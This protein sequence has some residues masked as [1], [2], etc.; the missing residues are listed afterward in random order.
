MTQLTTTRTAG[1]RMP[2]TGGGATDSISAEVAGRRIMGPIPPDPD[3]PARKQMFALM[4]SLD[5]DLVMSDAEGLLA[6]AG[7]DPA[8]DTSRVGAVGYCMSGRYAISLAVRHP[9]RVFAAASVYGTQLVTEAEDSPHRTSRLA[10]AELYYA[11]AEEDVWAPPE[12]LA[13]L[14][15]ALKT[16][17]VDAEVEIYPG[18]KH[19]FAFLA[20]PMAYCTDNA[21]MIA[22]AGAERLALGLTDPLSARARPRWPL[23]AAAAAERPTHLPGRKG[24]KA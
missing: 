24:A 21:A 19:G 16:D 14:S 4:N 10:R 7:A 9:E 3:H 2:R 6:F 17:R 11:C 1:R 8:A 12:T 20:P 23:D 18:T 13:A 15:E 22:L 5:I